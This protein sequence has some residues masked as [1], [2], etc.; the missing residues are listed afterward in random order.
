[1]EFKDV[2]VLVLVIGETG[3]ITCQFHV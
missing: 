3:G 2:L 1:L